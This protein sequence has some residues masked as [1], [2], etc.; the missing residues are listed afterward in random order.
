MIP[1]SFR[2]IKKV[3]NAYILRWTLIEIF[4]H[5]S[6]KKMISDKQICINYNIFYNWESFITFTNIFEL[7]ISDNKKYKIVI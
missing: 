7:N 1:N 6:I 5:V 2:G 3:S 4:I